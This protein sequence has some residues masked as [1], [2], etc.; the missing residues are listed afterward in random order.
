M[1]FNKNKSEIVES[2]KNL[3]KKADE[4]QDLEKS[5]QIITNINSKDINI[6]DVTIDVESQSQRTSEMLGIKSIK[7]VPSNPFKK[8]YKEQNRDR[9]EKFEYELNNKINDILNRHLYHWLNR[10]L[11]K[12]SKAKLRKYIYELLNQLVK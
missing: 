12:Y 9:Y 11:P 7:R 3:L 5:T 10:E 1:S 2:F 8:Q 6:V 4:V